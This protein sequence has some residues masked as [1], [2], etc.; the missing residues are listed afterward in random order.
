MEPRMAKAALSVPGV[1]D[2]NAGAEQGGR[3]C[4]R[5]GERARPVDFSRKPSHTKRSADGS[6]RERQLSWI[7][8]FPELRRREAQ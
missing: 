8:Y 5:S 7:P 6:H 4:R 2:S 3:R 1:V